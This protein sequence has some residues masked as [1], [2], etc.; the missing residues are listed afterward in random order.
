MINIKSEACKTCQNRFNPVWLKDGQCNGCRN[1]SAIVEA[2]TERYAVRKI[3][4]PRKGWAVIDQVNHVMVSG[5]CK[6]KK[7]AVQ[8]LDRGQYAIG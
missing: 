8:L 2:V 6:T 4:R 1:P 5:I 7:E 3:V